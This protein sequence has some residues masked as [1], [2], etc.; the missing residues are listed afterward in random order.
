LK[1]IDFSY[2]RPS[3]L[4]DAFELLHRDGDDG[5]T[6]VIAGGQSLMPMLNLRLVRPTRLIDLRNLG[7]LRQVQDD[8]DALIYGAGITHAMIEDGRV[9]D[10]TPGWLSSIAGDI[11]YRAVRNRGTIGGSLA[12]AD[13]AADWLSALT[14]LGG[15]VM[16]S[17]GASTRFLSLADFTLGAFSTA[18][19]ADEIMT[20]VRVR[21]RSSAARFGYWKYCRKAG[22]FAK[23][24]GAVLVDPD[25]GETTAVVGAIERAPLVLDDATELIREPRA[26]ES[27]VGA[28]LPHLDPVRRRLLGT[29]LERAAMRV[30]PEREAA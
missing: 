24:I 13:P 21:K 8:G 16:L 28:A 26:A 17:D 27:M 30:A 15:E 7:D 19:R 10:A 23:A 12:H 14:A 5:A 6:M 1:P 11:A 18:R 2:N 9:P 22:E 3:S 20:G 4:A 25:R 29:A